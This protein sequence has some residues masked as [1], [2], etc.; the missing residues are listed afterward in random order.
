MLKLFTFLS[1]IFLSAKAFANPACVVCTVAIGA[2][3]SV[4]RAFGVDDC[5][6]GVWTGAM[7]A[8][9]GYWLIRFFE[10]KNW[11]FAFRDSILM[12]ISISSVGFMYLSQLTYTPMIIGFLYMDSFLLTNII[13]A[14]ALISSM[15]FYAWMKEKNGGHAHF[16]FEKVVVPLLV[17][18]LVSLIFHYFPICNCDADSALTPLL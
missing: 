17:V 1:S 4:A 12:V 7:L 14:I 18:F 3:L 16:P 10:K 6:V 13:G 9:L 15:N 2:S 8:I 5:V 11:N